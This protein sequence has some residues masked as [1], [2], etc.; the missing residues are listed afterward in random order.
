MF[1]VCSTISW[2]SPNIISPQNSRIDKT[3]V[4]HF[5]YL[6]CNLLPSHPVGSKP[7]LE[8]CKLALGCICFDF[9]SN[10]PMSISLSQFTLYFLLCS[11]YSF[12]VA[13]HSNHIKSMVHLSFLYVQVCGQRILASKGALGA[14]GAARSYTSLVAP[15]YVFPCEHAFHAQCLTDY[16][17]QH[18]D[19]SEV[20]SNTSIFLE[21]GVKESIQNAVLVNL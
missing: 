18:T 20:P 8:K 2:S 21:S 13:N 1:F 14:S 4:P 10:L 5:A 3:T 19:S 16:V 11:I 9:L 6:F 15:F 17:L 12:D 7:C